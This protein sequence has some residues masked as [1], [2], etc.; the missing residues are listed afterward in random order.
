M[1]IITQYNPKQKQWEIFPAH[2]TEDQARQAGQVIAFP[3]G[4]EGH[5]AAQLSALTAAAP[6][7]AAQVDALIQAVTRRHFPQAIDRILRAGL[8][9]AQGK[10][11]YPR[12]F[13]ASGSYLGEV[14]RI[15]SDREPGLFYAVTQSNGSNTHGIEIG[16]SCECADCANGVKLRVLC[17]GTAGRPASGAPFIP[18]FGYACKHTLAYYI[19]AHIAGFEWG[20]EP[21]PFMGQPVPLTDAEYI[22][23]HCPF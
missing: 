22:D 23:Y 3:A 4:K 20:E 10:V 13:A 11:C 6:A 12:P 18:G 8:L 5:R 16:L 21:I 14:A 19:A 17:P 7:V 1:N 2:L 15:E 9:A